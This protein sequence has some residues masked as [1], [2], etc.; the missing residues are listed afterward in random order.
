M[1]CYFIW[2]V[3][4]HNTTIT[5]NI[6]GGW[7]KGRGNRALHFLYFL[8]TIEEYDRNGNWDATP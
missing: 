5:L 3:V 8:C 6:G 4:S 1:C 2:D 7:R